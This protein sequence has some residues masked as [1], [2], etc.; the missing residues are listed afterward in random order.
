MRKCIFFLAKMESWWIII[1][2]EIVTALNFLPL[3]LDKIL[4]KISEAELHSISH[5]YLETLASVLQ[6]LIVNNIL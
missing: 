3:C 5:L 6:N 2:T 4:T 1:F